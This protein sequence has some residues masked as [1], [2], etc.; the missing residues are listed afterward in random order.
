MNYAADLL[1]NAGL[2][3]TPSKDAKDTETLIPYVRLPVFMLP[4]GHFYQPSRENPYLDAIER[5]PSASPTMTGM[6][7][8]PRVLSPKCFCQSGE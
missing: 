5:Q 2:N 3:F 6:S 4:Y 8:S 7:D 1:A